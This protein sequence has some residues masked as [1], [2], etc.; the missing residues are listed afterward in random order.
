MT[1]IE[2]PVE[3]PVPAIPPDHG[4]ED[5][6]RRSAALTVE[7]HLAALERLREAGLE[8]GQI[9]AAV[10]AEVKRGQVA[11]FYARRKENVTK[12]TPEERVQRVAAILRGAGL[13]VVSADEQSQVPL[14]GAPNATG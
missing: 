7:Q 6:R 5:R 14:S 2:T 8:T 1:G 13:R 9:G 4:G 3:T 10:A 11:G 12:V